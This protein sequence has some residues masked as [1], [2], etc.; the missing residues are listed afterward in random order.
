MTTVASGRWTSAP[1]PWENAIGT[2]PRLAT[3]PV[4][5]MGRKRAID[6][7][8]TARSTGNP[9]SMRWRIAETS[10]KPSRTATPDRAMKPTPAEMLKFS[11][12]SHNTRMP[13]IAPS[14]TDRKISAPS[15]IEWNVE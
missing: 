12:R 2:N 1:A 9:S 4:I 8:R 6:A 5:R 14:G 15:R 10:T 3:R 7:S 11:P 13:P